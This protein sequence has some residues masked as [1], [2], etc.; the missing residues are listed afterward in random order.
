MSDSCVFCTKISDG[1]DEHGPAIPTSTPDVFRFVPLNPVT[2]GHMLFVPR[3]HYGRAEGN[4]L[5]TSETVLALLHYVADEGIE[6][7]NIIQSNGAEATQTV[8]H[9][10]FHLVPRRSGDL[11]SLPWTDGGAVVT[12]YRSIDEEGNL[13]CESHS[14]GEVLR[15]SEGYDGTLTYERYAFVRTRGEWLPWAGE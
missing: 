6:S 8:P 9:V 4:N 5:Y 11:L 15:M 12:A 10:H 14:P 13:W 3:A 7:Y 1:G 2:K